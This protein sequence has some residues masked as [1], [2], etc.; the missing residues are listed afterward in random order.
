MKKQLNS[1]LENVMV[2][3]DNQ[4]LDI[5]SSDL[6]SVRTLRNKPMNSAAMSNLLS[7]IKS[8]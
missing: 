5:I 7:A 2:K 4:L 6:R 8:A 3:Y 1:A